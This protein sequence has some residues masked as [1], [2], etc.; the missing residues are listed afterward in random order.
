MRSI[1]LLSD[2]PRAT[3]QPRVGK[4][5]VL[6][7]IRY[8]A[9]NSMETREIDYDRLGAS[10]GDWRDGE[11]TL[12][13]AGPAPACRIARCVPEGGA[14]TAVGRRA[15]RRRTRTASSGAAGVCR[16]SFA[17]L[18]GTTGRPRSG[19]FHRGRPSLAADPDQS[20]DDG[21]VRSG[22]HGPR[23]DT[24]PGP[25]TP[26]SVERRRVPGRR[27]PGNRHVW[28][29]RNRSSPCLRLG[30]VR[31]LRDARLA[32]DRATR[33]RPGRGAGAGFSCS[34]RHESGV[35]HAFSTFESG[36]PASHCFD[37]THPLDEIVDGLNNARPAVQALQGWPS[38]I[39]ELA[40]EAIARTTHHQ[41]DLGQRRGRALHPA[42]ARGS[43]VRVGDR[44]FGVLGLLG[45][46]LCLSM[47]RW[48]RHA[49][50][51]RSGHSRAGGCRWQRRPL[52]A[53]CGSAA[54]DQPVQPGAAADP[55]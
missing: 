28:I 18:A 48:R 21:G 5:T 52:R 16:R 9:T 27:V 19:E 35:F 33:R 23:V 32:L 40:L 7:H 34:T 45:G 50:R 14:P 31:H 17:V 41:T 54:V 6:R 53:T 29:Y 47:R 43:S 39:R 3:P 4:E 15:S 44:G 51:R 38:L 26:R 30:R 49:R 1:S 20:R 46:H 37:G 2:G 25:T 13:A 11:R 36:G 12:R 24:R 42:R 8:F 22:G 55:L 10:D